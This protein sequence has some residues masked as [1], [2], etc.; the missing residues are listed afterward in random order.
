[1]AMISSLGASRPPSRDLQPE[2]SRLEELVVADSTGQAPWIEELAR[3]ATDLNL[4]TAELRSA[5]TQLTWISRRLGQPIPT[6]SDHCSNPGTIGLIHLYVCGQRLRFDFNFKGLETFIHNHQH[7][8]YAPDALVQSFRVFAGLGARQSGATE[9][10]QKVL[11][12]EDIDSRARQVCLAGIWS[13]YTVPDQGNLLL[14]L[15]NEMIALGE[16]DGTVYFRRA[17]ANRLLGNYQA[18]LDDIDHA[19]SMVQPGNNEIN[20]DYLRE[21]QLIGLASQLATTQAQA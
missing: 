21:R 15:A 18:A 17:A 12:L 20:Q 19:L 7:S 4:S 13:A 3:A 11:R 10:L 6:L 14:G 2:V 16:A 1:M 9:D 5:A 8:L